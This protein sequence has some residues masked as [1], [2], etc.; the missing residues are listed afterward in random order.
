MY[1]LPC[2]L[3]V[4]GSRE[5]KEYYKGI[6]ISSHLGRTSYHYNDGSLLHLHSVYL[7][8]RRLQLL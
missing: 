8:S 3:Y 6:E 5:I 7:N 2:S 4:I 1:Q